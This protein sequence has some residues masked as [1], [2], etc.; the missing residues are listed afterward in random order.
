M[1]FP[2]ENH[3]IGAAWN[4]EKSSPTTLTRLKLWINKEA[5]LT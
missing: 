2:H 4:S 1:P 5:L 3:S